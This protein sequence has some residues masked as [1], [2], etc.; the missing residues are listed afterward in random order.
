[1]LRTYYHIEED[2][3][4]FLGITEQECYIRAMSRDDWDV[5]HADLSDPYDFHLEMAYTLSDEDYDDEGDAQDACS[6]VSRS[7]SKDIK[8]YA[9][10]TFERKIL[11]QNKEAEIGYCIVAPDTFNL[12]DELPEEYAYCGALGSCGLL[13]EPSKSKKQ[14]YHPVYGG[15]II[16]DYHTACVEFNRRLEEYACPLLLATVKKTDKGTLKADQPLLL[17]YPRLAAYSKTAIL[18]DHLYPVYEFTYYFRYIESEY[19]HD[20]EKAAEEAALDDYADMMHDS[21]REREM[22]D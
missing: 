1:M 14:Y 15:V 5:E 12:E 20:A 19:D 2:E 9:A 11:G 3:V 10:I 16:K 4:S 6:F 7:Q 8:G 13:R 17:A 18:A 21:M 22:E